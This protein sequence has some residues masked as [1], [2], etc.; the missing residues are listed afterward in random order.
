MKKDLQ[1][2]FTALW[3]QYFPNADLPIGFYYSREVPQAPANVRCVMAALP[4]VR[5]GE[6]VVLTEESI[7]CFGA[8][9]YLGYDPEGHVP[10]KEGEPYT[11]TEQ[12][13][14]TGVPGQVPGERI[15]QSPEVCRRMYRNVPA[16]VPPEKTLV[17]K[18]WDK[19]EEGETPEVVIFYGSG[20]VISG[21]YNLVSYDR[22]DQFALVAPWGS[23]CSSVISDPYLEVGKDRPRAILGLL[24]V[25]ARPFGGGDELTI[26]L[27]THRL[28]E[29]V[30]FME[31]SFLATPAWDVVRRR[32]AGQGGEAPAKP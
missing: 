32:M 21:L 20:D 5:R 3:T 6:T 7:Q 2:R 29:I 1:G 25:A 23:G 13:L 19:F 27:P 17:F 28:E 14:S 12:F 24:D 11:F 30:D 22:D 15:K 9:A 16:L 26:A 31:E 18:R 10:S 8:K 4:R